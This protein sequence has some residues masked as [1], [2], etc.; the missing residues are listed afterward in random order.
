MSFIIYDTKGNEAYI[1]E[2]ANDIKEA[3]REFAGKKDLCGIDLSGQSLQ[4]IDLDTLILRECDFR[5][6]DL[7]GVKIYN[8]N[9][10]GSDFRG[11]FYLGSF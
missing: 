10:E 2:S 6:S 5:N 1:S 8:A 11:I 3:I 9:I 4:G 7:S